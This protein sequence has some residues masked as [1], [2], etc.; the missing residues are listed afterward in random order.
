MCDNC[1]SVRALNEK[2]TTVKIVDYS[3]NIYTVTAMPIII[4]HE[5]FVLE[6]IQN[7]NSSI[8]SGTY[9]Q[10]YDAGVIMSS[11]A[12]YVDKL[13]VVDQLT[14]LYN[15]RFIDERLPAMLNDAENT[16]VP[17][18]I[19]FADIDFFKK[20]NDTYGHVAGDNVLKETASILKKNI[21]KSSGFVSRYGGEE[22]LICLTNIDYADAQNIA[23]RMRV[24]IMKN[25]FKIDKSIVSVTCSFGVYTVKDQGYYLTTQ[26]IISLA[27][28]N[29]YKAKSTGRNKVV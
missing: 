27:D 25:K 19:I 15:R 23:E 11:I 14:N 7:I 2:L 22:F 13:L 12:K 3:N 10:N 24:A 28:D 29:L 9:V 16:K 21:R 1:I 26:K 8:V 5:K 18:S 4:K 6:L 17:L 20:I